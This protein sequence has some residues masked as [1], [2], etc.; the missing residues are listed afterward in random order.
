MSSSRGTVSSKVLAWC[1]K[2]SRKVSNEIT[3]EEKQQLL[4]QKL[5]KDNQ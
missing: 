1:L 4:Q 2:E 5:K 3:E